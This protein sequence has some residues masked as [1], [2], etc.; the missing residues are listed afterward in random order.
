MTQVFNL[1]LDLSNFIHEMK[2]QYLYFTGS[3]FVVFQIY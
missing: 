1:L 2:L 3:E